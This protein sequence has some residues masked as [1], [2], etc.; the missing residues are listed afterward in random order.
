MIY[1]LWLLPVLTG[2]ILYIV[3]K[4]I[5]TLKIAGVC[6]LVTLLYSILHKEIV[7]HNMTSDTEWWGNYAVSVHYYDDWDEEV[8]CRHSYDCNCSTDKD[9]HKHC[10]TC[11][12][13]AYDVDYHPEYWTI[14]YDNGDEETISKSKY[15]QWCK[16]W[17]NNRYKRE[18][19]RDYHSNDGD[20]MACNWNSLPQTSE[21]IITEHSYENRIIASNSVFSPDK[22][23]SFDFKKYRLFEYPKCI[24]GRQKIVLGYPIFSKTDTLLRYINGY[25]GSR[26]EF[27]L[28]AT[29]WYNQSELAAERQ[30]SY[31]GNLNKNEFLLCLGLKPDGTVEWCKTYSWMDRP[32]LSVRVEQYFKDNPKIDL[33]KFAQWLPSAIETYWSRKHFREFKY[34]KVE[35][36]QSQYT[37]IFGVCLV[38]CIFQTIVTRQ[39][40]ND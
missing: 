35:I 7:E 32:T 12:R 15:E 5:I 11:Y 17:G 39:L 13:H 22:V 34:L 19:N 23:D 31:W 9:G 29:V 30:H 36:T 18:L 16:L 21:T 4:D 10:S 25:Y 33:T 1:L 14:K 38:L 27:K 6:V 20:D 3:Y 24:D 37:I 8:H 2:L 26:K 40:I 28:F